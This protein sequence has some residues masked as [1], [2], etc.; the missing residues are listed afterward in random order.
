MD[1]FSL[2][3]Q[4]P[5]QRSFHFIAALLLA[6]SAFS[7]AWALDKVDKLATLELANLNHPVENIYSSAQPTQDAFK[8]IAESGI[9]VVVN[10]RPHSELDWNEQALVESLGMTYI[11]LPISG[12]TDITTKNAQALTTLLAELKGKQIL[13]HCSSSNRV[14]ALSS[15]SAYQNN[16]GDIDA[17]VD[18][19]KKW[20]LTRLETLV[21]E[22]LSK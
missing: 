12:A 22:K 21:R 10:L 3:K 11:N 8:G 9:N 19:G 2:L 5:H 7:P 1:T 18:E 6:I 20:G 17:S 15:L 4:V 14:G 13:V 16:G